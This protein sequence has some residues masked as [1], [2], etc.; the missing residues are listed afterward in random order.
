MRARGRRVE[1]WSVATND[2]DDVLPAPEAVAADLAARGERVVL[3]HSHH[4]EAHRREFMMQVTRA[5][6][7]E[8]RRRNI[9]MVTMAELASAAGA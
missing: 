5:L 6:V 2:T 9:S 7:T 8:A 4:D 1:W 3:M